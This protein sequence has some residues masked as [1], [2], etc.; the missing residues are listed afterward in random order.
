MFLSL[1]QS[2]RNLFR[3]AGD[4]EGGGIVPSGR[5]EGEFEG[6]LCMPG[7]NRGSDLGG[8][9]CPSALLTFTAVVFRGILCGK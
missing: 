6:A 4:E 7:G 5:A 9:G 3:V 8:V 1:G 2:V